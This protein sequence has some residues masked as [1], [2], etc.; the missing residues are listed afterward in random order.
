MNWFRRS[1]LAGS[2]LAALG[3]ISFAA[4]S[5]G[6][7][8]WGGGEPWS[9]ARIDKMLQHLYI[10]IDATDAQK[11]KLTPIAKAAVKDLLPLRERARAA[12][13]RGIELLAG[14]RVDRGALEAL[15]SE[16]IGL[17]DQ[18]SRRLSQALADAAETLTP[19]QRK[20]L[21][22]RFARRHGRWGHG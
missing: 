15:R 6:H 17:A 9:E 20:D 8:G 5:H 7:R 21:A 19:A 22:A 1:M 18:A 13:Q 12:R 3:G 4:H 10:E 2:A 14:D 11:Q 16:Q